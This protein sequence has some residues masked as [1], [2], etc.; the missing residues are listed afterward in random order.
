MTTA[1][2][3]AIAMPP[4]VEAK[5]VITAI[6]MQDLRTKNQ[7]SKQAP[8]SR[9]KKAYPNGKHAPIR[10]LETPRHHAPDA[11]CR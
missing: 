8:P 4:I 2:L 6:A 10:P 9:P 7:R 1:E 11:L 5:I 3:G